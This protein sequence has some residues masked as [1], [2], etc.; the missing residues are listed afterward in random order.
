MTGR[1]K[2][3]VLFALRKLARD[4]DTP[5]KLR[6]EATNKLMELEG[7]GISNKSCTPKSG[8][9]A[10]ASKLKN[11]AR[12]LSEEKES[13]GSPGANVEKSRAA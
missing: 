9:E 7:W 8:N 4:K 3:A 2:Q 6:W 11:L 13:T 1:T 10:R 12:K 5:A